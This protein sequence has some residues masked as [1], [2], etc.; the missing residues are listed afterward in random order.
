LN[1]RHHSK[2]I[3]IDGM[4]ILKLILKKEGGRVWTGLIWLRIRTGEVAGCCEHGDEPSS[5]L[6]GGEFIG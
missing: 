3:S 4:I 6:N 1:G 5:S 2:D